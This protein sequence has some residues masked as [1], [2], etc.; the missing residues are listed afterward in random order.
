MPQGRVP[1]FAGHDDLAR[2]FP[3]S[4]AFS[5]DVAPDEPRSCNDRQGRVLRFA[6]H[7]DLARFFPA[8]P[9]FSDDLV[10]ITAAT[11]STHAILL[12]LCA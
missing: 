10:H 6:G 8:S 11:R 5:P 9:A 3:A 2:F 12:V 4:P 1:R 7:D